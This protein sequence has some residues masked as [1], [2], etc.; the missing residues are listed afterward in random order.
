MKGLPRP[1]G[2]PLTGS[3]GLEFHAE[4]ELQLPHGNVRVDVGDDTAIGAIYT[5]CAGGVGYIEHRMVEYVEGLELELT[6]YALLYRDVLQEG[7]VRRVLTRTR[8][9]I[10]TDVAE[11]CKGRTA[12]G[13]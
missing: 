11:G 3:C 8:E 6:L 10:A 7:S 13:A 1:I 5:A 9:R 12:E 2:S 4:G